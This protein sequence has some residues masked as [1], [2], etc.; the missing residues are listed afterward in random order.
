MTDFSKLTKEELIN[1]LTSLNSKVEKLEATKSDSV[2]TQ[3]ET[4]LDEGYNCIE[5][6]AAELDKTSKNV[7]TYLTY[8][9]KK[10]RKKDMTI[11][12]YRTNGKTYVSIQPLS[13]FGI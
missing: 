3:V 2:Q 6:I 13:I 5:D 11:V 12:S 1:H 7:S 10:L 4:L 9:R 8:I